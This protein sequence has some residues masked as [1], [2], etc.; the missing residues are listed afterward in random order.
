MLMICG[1]LVL[2]LAIRISTIV[3]W[4]MKDKENDIKIRHD[5]AINSLDEVYE[6]YPQ[7]R[8]N[9]EYL[10]QFASKEYVIWV[11]SEY[12]LDFIFQD[13]NGLAEKAFAEINGEVTQ[14]AMLP[15]Y[16]YFSKRQKLE[17]AALLGNAL[18]LAYKNNAEKAHE[19]VSYA[20]QYGCDRRVEIG[21]FW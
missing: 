5:K 6:E 13:I 1:C 4:Y 10:I 2:F 17:Y 9:I 20:K 14:I 15:G 11:D 3:L 12:E 19:M 18:H 21:R 8:G 7:I 16:R